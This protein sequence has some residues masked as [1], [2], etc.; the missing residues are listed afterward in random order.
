MADKSFSN[1]LQRALARADAD[2]MM[3]QTQTYYVNFKAG[4]PGWDETNEDGLQAIT[5]A[6]FHDPEKTLAYVM[7]AAA[8]FDDPEFLGF[9]AAGSL[10]HLLNNPSTEMLE[11]I[12]TEARKT[13][14]FRWMLSGV[15]LHAI[16]ER[17]RKP[18]QDAVGGWTLD[19]EPLP[20]RPWA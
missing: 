5:T 4:L 20:P 18:V 12:V 7:L 16:A 11:R 15:W 1:E 9:V 17:A 10:E 6:Y 8:N 2:E 13:P 3:R 19:N 14:R